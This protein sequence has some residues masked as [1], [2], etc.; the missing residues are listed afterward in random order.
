MSLSLPEDPRPGLTIV[1]P[2]YNRASMVRDLLESI[3]GQS[4]LPDALILV[5]DHSTD[6]TLSVLKDFESQ[7]K[8]FDIIVLSNSKKGATSARNLGLEHVR[9]DWTMFFDSDDLMSP[10]HLEMVMNMVR[11][12]PMV[13]LIG[14]DVERIAIDG[15][16]RRLVFE[17]DDMAWNNIMHGTLATQR[18]MAKTSLFRS[19]G[20]WNEGQPIWNDIEL[21]VRLLNASPRIV[22]ADCPIPTVTIRVNPSSITGDRWSARIDQYKVALKNLSKV[23]GS[24]RQSW[25]RLKTAI[26]AG[27]IARENPEAGEL[28]YKELLGRGLRT[29]IVYRWRKSG[30]RGAAKVFKLLFRNSKRKV[31]Q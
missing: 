21:G 30:L 15:S 5:D 22:K 25:I 1:V 23:L 17:T 24:E 18:Y 19:V 28:F 26:L 9:T 11:N 16:K 14:W 6:G 27:D 31:G 29:R 10:N 12:H 7:C 13:D 4:R 20:G 8:D 3:Q 2:V